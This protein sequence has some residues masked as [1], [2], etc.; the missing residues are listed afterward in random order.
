[1]W[2]LE[3]PVGDCH[4]PSP[5]TRGSF[6]IGPRADPT[7]SLP[8]QD[9]H[10]VLLRN[11]LLFLLPWNLGIICYESKFN[12]SKLINTGKDHMEC[13]IASEGICGL[14]V[15]CPP[16]ELGWALGPFQR[17]IPEAPVHDLCKYC[18]LTLWLTF[19]DKKFF[20]P[21]LLS[22]K[23]LIVTSANVLHNSLSKKLEEHK[24]Y[25]ISMITLTLDHYSPTEL[26]VLSLKPLLFP[27]S[28]LGLIW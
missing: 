14:P 17:P 1:M 15:S 9:G 26:H 5:C 3:E 11:T 22:S 4:A 8:T 12:S 6:G 16:P 7:W 27:V 19:S 13:C 21:L 20:Y 18:P 10:I 24:I 2:S 23:K 28:L 25:F